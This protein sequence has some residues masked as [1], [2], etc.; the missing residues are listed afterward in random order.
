M[1]VWVT[2]AQGPSSSS[3][4]KSQRANIKA[5]PGM[6]A[7]V[8]CKVGGVDGWMGGWGGVGVSDKRSKKPS[9]V[10]SPVFSQ[11]LKITPV[12]DAKS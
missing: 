4:N 8:L 7:G 2:F 11:N 10:S 12:P 1:K 5:G 9:K 3:A 6:K